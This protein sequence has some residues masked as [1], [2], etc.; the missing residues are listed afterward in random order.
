MT[1][2]PP[3]PRPPAR[4]RSTPPP[5]T[6]TPPGPVAA[7]V[8]ARGST[9]RGRV[10]EHN[11]DYWLSPDLFG[12]PKTLRQQRGELLIVADGMGGH[13][14]GEIAARMTAEGV[15]KGYYAS[16]ADPKAALLEAIKQ[17]NADIFHQQQGN[18][19]QEGMGS[20]LVAALFLPQQARMISANVGDSRLYRLRAGELKQMTIDH[21]WVNEKLRNREITAE[22]AAN[23]PYRNIITRA[24]GSG[25]DLQSDIVEYDLKANDTFLLCSDGLSNMVQ[26]EELRQLLANNDLQAITGRLIALANERGGPDNI[27]VLVARYG[28]ADSVTLRAP[29]GSAHNRWLWPSLGAAALLVALAAAFVFQPWKSQSL[30][31]TPTENAAASAPTATDTA[32]S[33]AESL[34]AVASSTV[35]PESAAT[36]T[37]GAVLSDTRKTLATRVITPTAT[38]A[39]AAPAQPA[40]PTASS[41][42][43]APAQS[44]TPTAR[45]PG[46]ATLPGPI[47]DAPGDGDTPDKEM[48]TFRWQAVDSAKGYRLELR[49]D[50]PGQTEWRALIEQMTATELPIRYDDQRDYFAIPGTVYYWRVKSLDAAGNGN[51]SVERRFVFNRRSAS[52]DKKPV[53]TVP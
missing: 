32:I 25:L 23:H 53:D 39:K 10:R 45:P 29:L 13:A 48:V 36:G 52:E 47:L 31:P 34:L 19:V 16:P 20:T 49:S 2:N 43:P 12:V 28:A 51:Y 27:T 26:P 17:T 7:A 42:T 33:N 37:S 4:G 8:V 50:R 11:E 41:P 3:T 24:M 14:A 1:A 22:E 21:T 6:V 40:A 30:A 44:A 18:T 38:S 5:P 35:K 15:M 9:D 46:G